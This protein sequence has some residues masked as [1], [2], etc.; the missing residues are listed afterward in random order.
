M[1]EKRP[2]VR[3]NI[4]GGVKFKF[5]KIQ[6]GKKIFKKAFRVYVEADAPLAAAAISFY[7]FLGMIP[8][9]LLL[10]AAIGFISRNFYHLTVVDISYEL[11]SFFGPHGERLVSFVNSVLERSASYGIFGL[12]G[13]FL[14]FSAVV[15]PIDWALKKVFKG[16]TM[17]SF[18]FQRAVSF[19]LFVL[20]IMGSFLIAGATTMFQILQ[21]AAKRLPL[22]QVVTFVNGTVVLQILLSFIQATLLFLAS[23]LLMWMLPVKKPDRYSIMWGALFSGIAIETGRQIFLSYLRLIPIYDIIYGAVGFLVV[24]MVFIYLSSALFLG[25]AAL[26]EAISIYKSEQI[27][28]TDRKGKETN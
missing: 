24:L 2:R 12:I 19:L 5:N 13:I 14:A 15:T 23:F 1:V 17:R 25:G 28:K 11:G 18:L 26:A 6:E 22:A 21:I 9:L 10:L 4:T 3:N 8:F 16:E 27:L 7:G 20:V